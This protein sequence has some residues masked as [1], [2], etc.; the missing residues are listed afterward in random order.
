MPMSRSES[1]APS[2]LPNPVTTPTI[3]VE[4]AGRAFGLGRSASYV[5]AGRGE[6]PVRHFGRKLRCP[7][8]AILEMLQQPSS[9]ADEHPA[10]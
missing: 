1:L 10:S 3:S 4:V 2:T 8:A 9:M 6:L 5:A 7:T